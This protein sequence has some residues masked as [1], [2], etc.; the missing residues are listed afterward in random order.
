MTLLKGG[1]VAQEPTVVILKRM[2]MRKKTWCL[3]R[4]I[5]MAWQRRWWTW[6]TFPLYSLHAVSTRPYSARKRTGW[7]AA[8]SLPCPYVCGMCVCLSRRITSES[9][10]CMCQTIQESDHSNRRRDII[11][12]SSSCAW[13]FSHSSSCDADRSAA[14]TLTHSHPTQLLSVYQRT[15]MQVSRLQHDLHRITSFGSC[16]YAYHPVSILLIAFAK[17]LGTVHIC[18]RRGERVTDWS[19]WVH[20]LH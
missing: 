2:R 7:D 9:S 4:A 6:V 11:R 3:G 16:V 12:S 8:N 17:P 15:W 20:I 10:W 13:T 1:A 18:C 5:R 14:K 19:P